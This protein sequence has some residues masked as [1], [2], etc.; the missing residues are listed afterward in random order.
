MFRISGISTDWPVETEL[1]RVRER[2]SRTINLEDKSSKRFSLVAEVASLGPRSAWLE[3]LPCV[4]EGDE[5]VFI[6][7][8]DAG[9]IVFDPV[10][11]PGVPNSRWRPLWR[12]WIFLTGD[13]ELPLPGEPESVEE[14]VA[15]VGL[16]PGHTPAGD[17]W[18]TGWIVALKWCGNQETDI[19]LESF[20]RFF[21]KGVT[22]WLSENIISDALEGKTW[23]GPLRLIDALQSNSPQEV[24]DAAGTLLQWG[25]TSG[26]AWLAGFASGLEKA[27]NR[28]KSS[29]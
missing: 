4:K 20:L 5:L 22:T 17:D 13:L 14:I 28:K 26:R 2:H 24:Q 27:F 7:L 19:L 9:T 11:K 15:L 10:I 23:I 3:E 1:F 18:I 6:P 12:E 29:I 16:G 25:H 8:P 21:Q